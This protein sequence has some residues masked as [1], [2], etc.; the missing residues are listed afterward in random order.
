MALP[1][2]ERAWHWPRGWRLAVA[3]GGPVAAAWGAWGISGLMDPGLEPAALITL[4]VLL[5]AALF[6]A[7]EPVPAVATSLAVVGVLTALVGVPGT[8]GAWWAKDVGGWERFIA[9]AASPLM[10]LM[11]GSLVLSAGAQRTGL[12]RALGA[13]LLKRFAGSPRRLVVGVLLVSAL[14]SMWTSNTA[15]AAI[16]LAVTRPV[17]S[18]GDLARSTRAGVALAAALGANCGGIATPIGTPPNTI[19]FMLLQRHGQGFDFVRWMLVGVPVSAIILGVSAVGLLALVKPGREP[20]TLDLAPASVAGEPPPRWAGPAAGGIFALTVALWLTSPWT[21]IPVAAAALVPLVFFPALGILRP[22]DLN[23]LEWDVL[24]LILGGLVLGGAMEWTG[25]ASRLVQALPIETLPT[26]GVVASIAVVAVVLSSFMS[27]TAVANLLCPVGLGIAS[28]MPGGAMQAVGLAIAFA[29]SSA[30]VF[31]V[32]TPPN[33]LAY[34]TGLF[35]AGTLM[36]VG[37]AAGVAGVLAVLALARLV[38]V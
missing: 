1:V 16:M 14:L 10:L 29:S 30:M 19:V 27:N 22:S 28:A 20:A 34:R 8:L 31:P 21:G 18:R 33:A 4:A 32:S 35:G 24:L 37:S 17:W 36:A 7:T 5:L 6:W 15:T 3:L 2:V 26:L 12:D 9:P 11:L 25:L 38:F 23:R 13:V